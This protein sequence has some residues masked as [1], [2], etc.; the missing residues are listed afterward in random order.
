MFG[1][2]RWDVLG[3]RGD[4]AVFL[5]ACYKHCATLD[6]GWAALSVGG[7]TL[8]EA[9]ASWFFG[10]SGGGG[11]SVAPRWLEEGCA[12]VGC[13]VGCPGRPGSALQDVADLDLWLMR[14][15]PLSGR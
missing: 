8:E 2:N 5:P 7:F 3:V 10:S 1:R 14:L 6:G 13:G 4:R 12:G 15:T 11:G 9:V